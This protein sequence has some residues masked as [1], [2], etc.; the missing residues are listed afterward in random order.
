MKEKE[1]LHKYFEN[2]MK[3]IGF[4]N[5][6]FPAAVF[7]SVPVGI[8][9]EIGGNEEIYLTE[10]QGKRL[11]SI[12]LENALNR[13]KNLFYDLPC[14]PNILRIDN[15]P[16]EDNIIEEIFLQTGLG[17][18]DEVVKGKY[19]D[20]ENT[21]EHLYWDLTKHNCRPSKLLLEIIKGDIGGFS[22]LCSNVY[23]MDTQ[24]QL[25]Y[26][27][28]DN[29]GADI[30]AADKN[31]LLPIYEKYKDWILEYDRADIERIFNAKS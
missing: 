30:V 3:M 28:Y 20:E 1:I 4:K 24:K 29:R 7:Y 19:T 2:T 5:N 13:A 25:L 6:K 15:Y 16:E 17:N 12:Y 31:L 22:C 9:F 27:L 8:R 21:V 18:P 10:P 11:N 14:Y 26:H 23:F